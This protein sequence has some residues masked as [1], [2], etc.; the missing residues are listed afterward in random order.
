M[1]FCFS[2]SST[3]APLSFLDTDKP[4]CLLALALKICRSVILLQSVSAAVQ[5][6]TFRELNS[7]LSHRASR[8][9]QFPPGTISLSSS[10]GE[11]H[12]T[13]T[14]RR[15]CYASFVYAMSSATRLNDTTDSGPTLVSDH[16][17]RKL[18]VWAPSRCRQ[19]FLS[20]FELISR[21]RRNPDVASLWLK[22]NTP[23]GDG[24]PQRI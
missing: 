1:F 24:R 10:H 19:C 18:L 6:P 23:S 17:N 13:V 5:P 11:H 22:T 16:L 2:P 3:F 20:P 21:V 7:H 15:V 12:N 14:S 4:K 8:P 9:L